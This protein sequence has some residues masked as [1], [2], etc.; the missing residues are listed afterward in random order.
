MIFLLPRLELGGLAGP[1]SSGSGEA[2]AGVL[3]VSLLRLLA[4]VL[5]ALLG[6]PLPLSLTAFSLLMIFLPV[7][8]GG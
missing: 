4:T 3:R 5:V 8:L 1:S 2:L 7:F 6:V